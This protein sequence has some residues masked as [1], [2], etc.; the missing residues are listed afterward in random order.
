MPRFDRPIRK[1]W[2]RFEYFAPEQMP[3]FP[4]GFTGAPLEIRTTTE[5]MA[6]Q[7]EKNRLEREDRAKKDKLWAAVQAYI[8]KHDITCGEQ[9]YQSDRIIEGSYAFMHEI[10]QIVGYREYHDEE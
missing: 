9:V 7:R 8:D 5:M 2:G 6:E 10:F 4:E 1:N 3:T